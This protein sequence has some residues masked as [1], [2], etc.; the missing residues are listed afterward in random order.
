MILNM[1]ITLF[2]P[3]ITTILL[4]ILVFKPKI[5]N[6]TVLFV[7]II[8]LCLPSQYLFRSWFLILLLILNLGVFVMLLS[9]GNHVGK[10]RYLLWITAFIH[11]L[12]LGN[13]WYSRLAEVGLVEKRKIQFFEAGESAYKI[14]IAERI[15]GRPYLFTEI[16][17]N[18]SIFTYRVDEAHLGGNYYAKAITWRRLNDQEV[19]LTL[20]D[21]DG[22]RLPKIIQL[23]KK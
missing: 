19:E 22:E 13:I 17:S 2:I 1:T 14:R 4:G 3:V 9:L 16:L 10:W 21:R 20:T 12:I 18:N 8:I 6:I 23:P 11:I 5:W 15:W 7:Y